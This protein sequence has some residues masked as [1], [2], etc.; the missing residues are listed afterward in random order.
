MPPGVFDILGFLGNAVAQFFFY[1]WWFWL[2][3]ILLGLARSAGLACRQYLYKHS[4]KCVFLEIR[5]PRLNEKSPQGME[6][7]LSAIHA[8]KNQPNDLGE[9]YWDGEVTR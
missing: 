7:V 4:I 6:Q 5:I 2:F 1:T 8:L 3:F 9:L